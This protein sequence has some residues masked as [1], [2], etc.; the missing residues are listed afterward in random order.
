MV[1]IK[2]IL[3]SKRQPSTLR[4]LIY[5]FNSVDETKLSRYIPST[6]NN[7][8]FKNFPPLLTSGSLVEFCSRAC[9]VFIC[10]ADSLQ[11]HCSFNIL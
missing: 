4:W 2:S 1:R 11:E 5:I 8:F 6:Q 3:I 10:T 7:N 9:S